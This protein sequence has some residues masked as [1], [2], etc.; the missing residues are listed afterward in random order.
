ML[1]DV[2]GKLADCWGVECW[3]SP[4][5]REFKKAKGCL[6]CDLELGIVEMKD[7]SLHNFEHDWHSQNLA[8]DCEWLGLLWT[9]FWTQIWV[10]NHVACNISLQCALA[11]HSE[12]KL[13]LPSWNFLCHYVLD[14]ILHQNRMLWLQWDELWLLLR[15][16]HSWCF[17]VF[18]LARSKKEPC[19]YLVKAHKAKSSL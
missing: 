1:V 7:L 9:Y 12:C 13:V 15:N 2:V 16:H 18:L 14:Q 6:H 4:I 8:P 10:E 11:S 3:V 5:D 17:F 19:W